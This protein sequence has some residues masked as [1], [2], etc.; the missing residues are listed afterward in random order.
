M[1]EQLVSNVL[2]L[3]LP[4]TQFTCTLHTRHIFSVFL[5]PVN[6]DSS[7]FRQDYLVVRSVS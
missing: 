6:V 2:S 5:V 4:D 1:L 7:S 3:S